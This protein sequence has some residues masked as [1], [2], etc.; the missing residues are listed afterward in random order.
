M[1]LDIMMPGISGFDVL[2]EVRLIS[3]VPVIILTA[4]HKEDD[5]IDGFDLG[6]DDYVTKPFSPKELVKRA[7]AVIRR[8]YTPQSENG[9]IVC[10]GFALDTAKQILYKN[11]NTI[12]LTSNEFFAAQGFPFK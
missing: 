7:E 2:R 5:K 9:L 4:K 8:V 11:N 3:K 10:G 6:A 1:I 12:E